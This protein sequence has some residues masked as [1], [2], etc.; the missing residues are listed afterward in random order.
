MKKICMWLV[1]AVFLFTFCPAWSGTSPTLSI[2]GLVK[3]PVNLSLSDLRQY[4]SVEAQLNEVF[5][6]GTYRGA[7]VFRGVPLKT[8]LETAF[9]QKEETDF[10]KRVDLAIVVKNRE[11]KQIVLSWGEVFYKN[12]G[13]IIVAFSGRPIMPHADC[14]RCHSPEVFKP[15]LDQ[16]YRQIGY[17]KLVV[18]GDAYADRSLE[19]ITSIQVVDLKPEMPAKKLKTLFSPEFVVM[20]AV[21]NPIT[22]TDFSVDF[23][24][25][26]KKTVRARHLGEGKGYHGIDL[27]GGASLRSVLHKAG[28]R[29]DVN[30][31]FLLSAP[32][33]YRVLLSY[34][35]VFLDPAGER[36][37]LADRMNNQPIKKNGKFFFVPPEDLMA[38]RD[39]K[40]VQKIE[41][42]SVKQNPRIYVIGVGCG[43]TGL[44]TLEAI[45]RMAE[46]DA[47]VCPPDIRKRFSKYM[48]NKP[49]L[50]NLYDFVS[51]VLKKKH[52][53]LSSEE[54]EILLKK[55]QDDA[56][57][58]IQQTLDEGKTVAI[59]EYGDP[60]IW[61]GWRWAWDSFPTGTIEIVPGLS[62]FNVSN[63]LIGEDLACN[64]S[65]VIATPRGLKADPAMVEAIAEKG[66]TLCIFMGLKDVTDLVSF[67]K[68]W[69]PGTMP[70][71]IV[72][73]AGY[74]A[75]E[76]LAR[77]TL[78]GL[79]NTA[80]S[81]KE[82]FLGLIYV[83]RC[84]AGKAG[85]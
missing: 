65:M 1:M 12:P 35:E 79:A 59:L 32:D 25:D 50:L 57:V 40:A 20:G 71:C 58:I 48:G 63:A 38:D 64:G 84:L 5:E 43:D 44:I 36:M 62:S 53:D 80:S 67:L 75:G 76:A 73:K 56:A 16:L 68:Q 30:T 60:G 52:P 3:Q 4:Q 74:S 28:I 6:D 81:A 37:I 27:M 15:R 19:E 46:A 13:R 2:T 33:G 24:T 11:G 49:V 22:V 54:L 7:F 45:S 72:Y 47:F 14:N 41:V 51:P 69:Y 21:E 10:K 55:E 17:P 70:A 34:G 42:I 66:E 23:S 18:A 8:L 77:T 85:N 83:G 26:P 29:P 82:K 31:V 78:D 9:I 39:V 61:S